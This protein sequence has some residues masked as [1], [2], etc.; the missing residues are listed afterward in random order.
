[1]A[2]FIKAC[3]S[4][5]LADAGNER[6]QSLLGIADTYPHHWR[7]E[8]DLGDFQGAFGGLL[9]ASVAERPNADEMDDLIAFFQSLQAPAN[10]LQNP[11]RVLDDARRNRFASS[12][13][14]GDAALLAASSAVRVVRSSPS[15]IQR[16]SSRM[17]STT[18]RS[19]EE[20][21]VARARPGPIR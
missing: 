10:P 9:G 12:V 6:A 3:A 21:S 19:A 4:C 17:T 18:S 15:R 11:R 5:Q 16:C 14:T 20:P 8:R 13:E 2:Q 7:G 1:M